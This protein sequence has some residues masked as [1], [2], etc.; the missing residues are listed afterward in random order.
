[1]TT[2]RAERLLDRLLMGALLASLLLGAL[3]ALRSAPFSNPDEA[4]HYLRSIEVARGHWLNRPGDAGVAIACRDYHTIAARHAPM[5][6]YDDVTR[7]PDFASDGCRVRTINTAGGYLPL[8]YLFL[9]PAEAI[10][11]ALDWP[12]ERR[13]KLMRFVNF[14]GVTLILAAAFSLIP[15]FHAPFVLLALSPMALWLRAAVSADGMTTACALLFLAWLLRLQQQARPPS[16]RQWLALAALGLLLGACK[17]VYG[18]IVFFALVLCFRPDP[19]R[20]RLRAFVLALLA[21]GVA[22]ALA[23]VALRLT[24]PMLIQ[25]AYGADPDVQ[26]ALV[27]ED[28]L[29]FVRAV[30]RGLGWRSFYE[31]VV[32]Y[33]GAA[34]AKGIAIAWGLSLL[35]IALLAFGPPFVGSLAGRWFAALFVVLLGIAICVP[36]Y[37]TYTPPGHH[38]VIGVQGRYFVPLVGVLAFALAGCARSL[39][40]LRREVAEPVATLVPLAVCA[41]LLV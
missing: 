8:S 41:A 18:L 31:I 6:L 21:G 20:D 38:F 12:I 4:A 1:M 30:Q 36:L 11:R 13:L 24:E 37:L 15:R 25:L 10:A 35:L 28:P 5:A 33:P 22:G 9:A 34:D 17:P 27:L 40:A 3:I 39:F 29:R 16:G 32:P 14:A 19:W 7:R 23:L 2:L 26:T